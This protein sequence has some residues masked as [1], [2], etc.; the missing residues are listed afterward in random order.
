MVHTFHSLIEARNPTGLEIFLDGGY[1]PKYIDYH[2]VLNNYDHQV[3]ACKE[4]VRVIGHHPATRNEYLLYIINFA[5]FYLLHTFMEGVERIESDQEFN[6]VIYKAIPKLRDG[7][8]QFILSNNDGDQENRVSF[9][10]Y[11][12]VEIVDRLLRSPRVDLSNPP[13]DLLQHIMSEPNLQVYNIYTR[14]GYQPYKYDIRPIVYARSDEILNYLLQVININTRNKDGETALTF[15]AK[16][17]D[18]DAKDKIMKLIK[19]GANQSINQG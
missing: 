1:K 7:M 9:D 18:R 11:P 15:L 16:K 10:D 13:E 12:I 4:I 14:A 19:L 8:R 2:L 6:Q 3:E 17:N 5:Q